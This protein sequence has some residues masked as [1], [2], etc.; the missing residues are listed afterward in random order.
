MLNL[1]E[2]FLRPPNQ[3][4]ITQLENGNYDAA[5]KN[6]FNVM[7]CIALKKIPVIADYK[8][9]M[10]DAGAKVALM[11]GSGP[12]VFALTDNDLTATKIFDSVDDAKLCITKFY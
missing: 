12:T 5:F 2:K 10:I 6:F 3:E 7:E 11:S 8:S 9:K 1:T 4:I